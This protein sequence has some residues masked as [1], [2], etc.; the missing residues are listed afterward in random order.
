MTQIDRLIQTAVG[1]LGYTE[2]STSTGRWNKYANE[3]GLLN[4]E[5]IKYIARLEWHFLEIKLKR[6]TN[7]KCYTKWKSEYEEETIK[8]IF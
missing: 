5:S 1:E 6:E 2:S 7:M 4:S 8:V 3:T